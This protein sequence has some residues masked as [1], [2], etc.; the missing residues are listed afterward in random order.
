MMEDEESLPSQDELDKLQELMERVDE[1]DARV[2]K[3]V[4]TAAV[5]RE[6]YA[7]MR[8]QYQRKAAQFATK[9][10]YYPYTDL[11]GEV[12]LGVDPDG[13][14]LG[15][16]RRQLN[17]HMLVVGRTG[18][19]KTT[20]FY[21]VIDACNEKGLP[22]LMFDFKN[23]YRDVAGELDLSVMNWRELKFNPLQPPPGVADER[24]AEALAQTWAHAMGFMTLSKTH[25]LNKLRELYG[26]SRRL[27]QVYG[28]RQHN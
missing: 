18:A 15:V 23:D 13:R 7:D 11:A 5:D 27:L 2:E 17:E 3:V 16:S 24:W 20:F 4:Q 1:S 25:F 19:G 28:L 6:F 9:G 14:P 10:A 22:V 26:Q 12:M 8:S 21:N